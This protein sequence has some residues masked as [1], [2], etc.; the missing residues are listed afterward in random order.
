M[1]R[2]ILFDFG[3]TLVDSASGFRSAEKQVQKRIYADLGGPSRE[4]FMAIY[5][6]VR[7]EFHATS[8]FSRKAIWREVYRNHCAASSER[9]LA[10]WEASY[11]EKVTKETRVFPEAVDVLKG[12]ER[13]Y[14]LGLITN[15]QGQTTNGKHRLG[16]YPELAAFFHT[17][18]VAGEN[19]VPP[20][21]DPEPFRL[22]LEKMGLAA[23]E[24][25]YV[26]DDWRIDVCGAREAGLHPV[27]LKHHTVIRNW[28]EVVSDVPVI[29][30]LKPLLDLEEL[31][32]E[33][34]T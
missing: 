20:K 8:I 19:W 7:K 21:P 18:V 16:A 2:A 25:V 13:K 27:W 17:I 23:R 14:R 26:G 3:Q 11:W 24:A 15:T 33:I 30:S 1:I 4:S 28:P 32:D 12:L 29:T 22:C 10:S 5:R 9:R 34:R 31:I 6:G